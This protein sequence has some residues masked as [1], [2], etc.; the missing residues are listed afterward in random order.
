MPQCLATSPVGPKSR[1]NGVEASRPPIA[2]TQPRRGHLPHGPLLIRTTLNLIEQCRKEGYLV[3]ISKIFDEIQ[4][5]LD[6]A[7]KDIF[8]ASAFI[9][10]CSVSSF[11][12]TPVVSVARMRPAIPA[13]GG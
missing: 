7:E 6:S 3:F 4:L 5:E 12:G 10:F 1:C 11:G 13:P 2:K 8:V 9:L